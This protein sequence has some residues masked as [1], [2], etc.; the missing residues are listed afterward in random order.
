AGHGPEALRWMQHGLVLLGAAAVGAM[1]SRAMG[2]AV[3]LAV[4]PAAWQV[5]QWRLVAVAQHS[6][7]RRMGINF[8][9]LLA[10]LPVLPIAIGEVAWAKLG[11]QSARAAEMGSLRGCDFEHGV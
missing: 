1:V 2:T 7:A 4:L 9:M 10:V 3:A 8:L 6:S 5:R 11:H